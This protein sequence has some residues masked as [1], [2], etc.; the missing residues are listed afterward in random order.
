MSIVQLH[1]ELAS[2]PR[3]RKVSK[4]EKEAKL[5][6]ERDKLSDLVDLFYSKAKNKI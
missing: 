2:I 1:S 5:K 6:D 4:I 3:P